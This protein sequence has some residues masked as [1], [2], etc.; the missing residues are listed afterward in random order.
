MQ[1]PV[2]LEVESYN[3]S[4]R[5]VLCVLK[6]VFQSTEPCPHQIPSLWIMPVHEIIKLVVRLFCNVDPH[7]RVL[8]SVDHFQFRAV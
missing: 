3:L 5:P 2:L 4:V 8:S 7:A 1:A 6:K